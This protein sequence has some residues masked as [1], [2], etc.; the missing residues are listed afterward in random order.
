MLE[1][2][3]VLDCSL[4]YCGAFATM[5]LANQGAKVYKIQFKG[6]SSVLETEGLP[7]RGG[8]THFHAYHHNK[9]IILIDLEREADRKKWEELVLQ[10][11]ILIEDFQEDMLFT[12]ETISAFKKNL[13]YAHIEGIE[14]EALQASSGLM[15][16][17]GFSDKEPTKVGGH[18]IENFCGIALANKVMA[19]YLQ[20]LWK[21]IGVHIH[22]SLHTIVLSIMESPILFETMLG[23]SSTR[24]GNG[25]SA[26]L[27]PYD[28]YAC[29]DGYFSAGLASDSGW[30]RYCEAVERL[31]LL[32]NELF[33][34]NE[35]RCKYY[36]DV[37]KEISPFFLSKTRAELAEIFAIKKIPNAPVLSVHEAMQTEQIRD[38]KMLI[39]MDEGA[40]SLVG[41]PIQ[42]E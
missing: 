3:V 27:V 36:D 25:D 7:F 23:I 12:C 35:L 16:M 4:G 24:C 19:G 41:N 17:T 14:G 32:E 26:T 39:Q 38:R 9:E 6:K 13:V 37:T 22:F 21:N 1:N 10:S 33:Q 8:H 31:D 34:T 2:V 11:H 20:S 29:K 5:T 28:V 42:Y 40:Y 18:M 15:D 30:D